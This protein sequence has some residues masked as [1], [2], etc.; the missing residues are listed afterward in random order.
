[1]AQWL[2]KSN[3]ALIIFTLC[4]YLNNLRIMQ[5]QEIK[6]NRSLT[7]IRP[8]ISPDIY[9]VFGLPYHDFR[10]NVLTSL[11]LCFQFI[12]HHSQWH[13]LTRIKTFTIIS[14]IH[15]ISCINL[16]RTSHSPLLISYISIMQFFYSMTKIKLLKLK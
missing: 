12:L 15:S 8:H 2:R 3:K 7:V 16:S 6:D 14:S 9:E 1:M 13:L 10:S 4:M 5:N 11:L